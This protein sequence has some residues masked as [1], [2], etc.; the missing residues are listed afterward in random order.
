MA[1]SSLNN[2]ACFA[3]RKLSETHHLRFAQRRVLGRKVS[4]EFT[5][6]LCR[7]HHREVHRC[8]DELAWWRKTGIDPNAAARTFWLETPPLPTI[9]DQCRDDEVDASLIGHGD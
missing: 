7:G 8:G 4:D 1:G 2:R 3:G 9:P 5:V 6:L